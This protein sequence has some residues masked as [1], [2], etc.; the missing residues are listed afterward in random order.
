M[1]EKLSL[2]IM[3]IQALM[4]SLGIYFISFN[5][6]ILKNIGLIILFMG[7]FFIMFF[8]YTYYTY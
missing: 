7:I 2:I 8:D 4:I 6:K 5:V 1:S 3:F